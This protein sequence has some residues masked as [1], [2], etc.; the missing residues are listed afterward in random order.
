MKK[1]AV[2]TFFKAENYGGDLQAYAL[3]K[4]LKMIGYDVEVL[5]QLCPFHKEY[6][7]SNSFKPII[8]LQDRV[9]RKGK[10]NTNISKLISKIAS[11]FFWKRNQKRINRFLKFDL[12]FI[13]PTLKIFY[14]FDILYKEDL[15]FDIFITGSDQVW[16]YTNGF[17]PE[18]FFLTFAKEGKRKIAYAASIGHTTIPEEIQGKYAEWFNS[19]DFISTREV[20]AENLVK[21]ISDKDAITVLDPIFLLKKEDWLSNLNIKETV[22]DKYLLI[23]SLAE[24]TYIFSLALHIAKK[25]NLKILNIIPNCWTTSHYNNV[26][27]IFDAGPIEFVQLFANASF[28]LTNSFHG[29][30]FSINFNIPFFALPRKNKKNNSRFINILDKTKLSSRLIYDGSNFPV[31]EEFNLSFNECNEILEVERLKSLNFLISSIEHEY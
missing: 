15:E 23:Y 29:T 9:S 16:N 1:I 26:K 22:K 12:E 30:S 6:I 27:N 31:D 13:K 24:S 3:Q 10:I 4:K 7:K 21:E 17:S 2:L 11:L 8:E 25:K 14:N 28:V 20:Q 18:P 19:L 5:H